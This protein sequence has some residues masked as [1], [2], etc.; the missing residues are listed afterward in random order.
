M[1]PAA[2]NGAVLGYD[3]HRRLVNSLDTEHHN[4]VDLRHL[5]APSLMATTSPCL[6]LD[7]VDGLPPLPVLEQDIHCD[8][9][10]VGAGFTGLWTAY[11]INRLNP[12]HRIVIVDAEQP[13]FGASGRNGGWVMGHL[14]GLSHLLKGAEKEQRDA[15]CQL[16]TGLLSQFADVLD[17]ELFDCDFQHGGGLYSACRFPAQVKAAQR[18]LE[19]LKRLGFSADDYHWLTADSAK[20]R[21]KAR[22]TFGAIATPHV[23][24]IH[25]VKLLRELTRALLARGVAVFRDSMAT[26]QSSG[27]LTTPK[28]DLRAHQVIWATEGYASGAAPTLGRLLPVQSGMIAT[29]PLSDSQWAT[30]GFEGRPAFCDFSRLSS[31]LQRTADNRLVVGARGSL[32]PGHHP[33]KTLSPDSHDN[34]FRHALLRDLFPQLGE[35]EI[36]HAWGG[37]LGVPRHFRPFVHWDPQINMGTAGG[38]LGEGVG[39]SFLFGQTLA[40]I[41]LNRTSP[42]TRAPWVSVGRLTSS[43]PRWEPAPLPWLGFA[44]FKT[45]VR[46]LESWQSRYR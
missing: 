1:A 33:A 2:P 9:A 20:H 25:P 4:E 5:G 31:Y 17:R 13:G 12:E 7:E 46:A 14:E 43:I 36:T 29:A 11:W 10:I 38:Y 26:Q 27:H 21:V 24:V 34:R 39:A 41:V 3:A 42:R 40:E 32:H 37:S 18:E 15:T 35:V 22:H 16:L 23:G 8:T 6:W 28:G 44:A 45:T 30:I 19:Q